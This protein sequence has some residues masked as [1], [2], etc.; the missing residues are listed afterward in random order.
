MR[1]SLKGPL[2][3]LHGTTVYWG[4]IPVD[5]QSAI[6]ESMTY[7][8]P[9]TCTELAD[10]KESKPLAD[11]RR[12]SAYVLLGDPGSGKT[13]AFQTE[14]TELG[15]TALLVTARDF[16]TFDPKDHPEWQGKTLF[17]DGLDEV[18]AGQSDVRTRFDLIRGRLDA[19]GRPS[20]RLSCR[21]ADWLGANDR[22]KLDAVSSNG[23]VTVLHL[24]PLSQS[25]VSQILDA[26][27]DICDSKAFIR[28]ARERGV[29]G[30]LTNPQTLELLVRLVAGGGSWPEGRRETFEGACSQMAAE[31]NTEH[32]IVGQ[33]GTIEQILDAAGRLCAIQLTADVHGYASKQRQ[34]DEDF[35]DPDRCDYENHDL[36][37]SALTTKLFTV[38]EDGRD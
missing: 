35:I 7:I 11:L 17:I 4:R 13:T 33:P 2:S 31:H 37:R 32:K 30:L 36:L 16:I 9:R 28:V 24:D 1:P 20:F 5:H 3:Q 19:L 22:T 27:R 18:R 23:R 26:H 15:A 6:D 10:R 38:D 14:C 12:E 8:V 25:D 21:S 34:P 29:D